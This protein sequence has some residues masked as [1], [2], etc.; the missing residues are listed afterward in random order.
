MRAFNPNRDFATQAR[1][2]REETQRQERPWAEGTKLL[3][4]EPDP[5]YYG[6][7][8]HGGLYTVSRDDRYGNVELEETRA[9]RVTGGHRA[10]RFVK[11]EEPPQ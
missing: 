6:H 8:E 2:L 3:C 11:V 10:S 7:L 4:V 5:E 9:R 1:A